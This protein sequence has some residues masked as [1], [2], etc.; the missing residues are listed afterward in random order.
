MHKL[1]AIIR[2]YNQLINK[3]VAIYFRLF[4]TLA[5]LKGQLL[6]LLE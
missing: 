6:D 1:F 4:Y 2:V 5:K 3:K